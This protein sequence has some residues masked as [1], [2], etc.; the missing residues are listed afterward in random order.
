MRSFAE[1][2]GRRRAEQDLEAW[3]IQAEAS[4]LPELRS[5]ANG[6]RRAQDAVTAGLTQPCRA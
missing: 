3:L 1:I 2:M 5:F 4:G 6:I